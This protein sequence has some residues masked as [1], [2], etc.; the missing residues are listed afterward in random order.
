MTPVFC[1]CHR[2]LEIIEIDGNTGTKWFE[3]FNFLTKG[4]SYHVGTS[5]LICRANQ[6]TGFYM[7]TASVMKDLRKLQTLRANNSRIRRIYNA[8]FSGYYFH[9]NTNIWRDFPICISVSLIGFCFLTCFFS[10]FLQ[11]VSK[12]MNSDFHA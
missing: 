8:K 11:M 5:P 6:W 12:S 3:N 9:I 4:R 2:T 10:L 7:I 1:K